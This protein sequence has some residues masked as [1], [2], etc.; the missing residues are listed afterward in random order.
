MQEVEVRKIH[1]TL[2]IIIVWF[3][4]IQVL[5]GLLIALGALMG[6]PDEASWLS[7]VK[8]VHWDWNPLGSILRLVLGLAT[9]AQGIGG[10]II[11]RM[12]QARMAKASGGGK[13]PR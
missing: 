7:S 6:T 9:L 5:T 12:I 3:L 4:A 13:K 11:Y 1:R 10:I 2:G 8:A